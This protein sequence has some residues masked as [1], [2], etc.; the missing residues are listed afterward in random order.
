MNSLDVHQRLSRMNHTSLHLQTMSIRRSV[1]PI[2]HPHWW[3]SRFLAWDYIDEVAADIRCHLIEI[4]TMWKGWTVTSVDLQD[5]KQLTNLTHEN[6]K[7]SSTSLTSTWVAVNTFSR[8]N[9]L[10]EATA[11]IR[12]RLIQIS[13]S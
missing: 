10:D 1:Q 9:H 12:C 4:V 5:L 13:T 6:M 7:S 11:D 2:I 3:K 8:G